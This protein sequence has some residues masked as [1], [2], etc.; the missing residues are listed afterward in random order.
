MPL[1]EAG[2]VIQAA[3]EK[4]HAVAVVGDWREHVEVSEDVDFP[5]WR[6]GSGEVAHRQPQPPLVPRR[7]GGALRV[8]E[9]IREVVGTVRCG[10]QVAAHNGVGQRDDLVLRRHPVRV[11]AQ[12]SLWSLNL[13][14]LPFFPRPSRSLK[15][16]YSRET[17]TNFADSSES[18]LIK[19]RFLKKQFDR[20]TVT[21]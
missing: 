6:E 9:V 17:R 7:R 18:V 8:G 20:Q 19:C 13:R 14:R 10:E 1:A 4:A 2:V 11:Q 3:G 5:R 12:G 16:L 15:R 21:L